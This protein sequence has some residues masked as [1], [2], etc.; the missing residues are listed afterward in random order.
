[1][2]EIGTKHAD[3]KTA[4]VPDPQNG[5][6]IELIGKAEPRGE[7][8]VGV[9]HVSM[10]VIPSDA[11]NADN[12]C[13]DVRK[14]TLGLSINALWEINLPAQAVGHRKFRRYAP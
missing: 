1:M 11:G 4:P 6:W 9:I 2:A 14:P 5:F 12:A 8:F 3:V 7:C 10:Q 13:V